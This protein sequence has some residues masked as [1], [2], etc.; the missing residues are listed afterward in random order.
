MMQERNILVSFAGNRIAEERG[1]NYYS[2]RVSVQGPAT[3]GNL[4]KWHPHSLAEIS[5]VATDFLPPTKFLEFL[6]IGPRMTS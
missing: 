4:P 2:T 3:P 1:Q 6:E 5:G